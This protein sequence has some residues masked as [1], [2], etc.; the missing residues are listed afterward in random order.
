MSKPNNI[1]DS[2]T[3]TDISDMLNEMVKFVDTHPDW[4]EDADL[5]TR[6]AMALGILRIVCPDPTLCT[7][8][9]YEFVI[10][11]CKT[12]NESEKR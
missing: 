7:D 5:T 6:M 10:N 11:L 1:P 4:I 3:T 12:L 8:D 2:P 9:E